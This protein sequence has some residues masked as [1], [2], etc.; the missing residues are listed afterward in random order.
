MAMMGS[1]IMRRTA[2]PCSESRSIPTPAIASR[3][4]FLKASTASDDSIARRRD[5][6][7]RIAGSIASSVAASV[8]QDV[9]PSGAALAYLPSLPYGR[10][11]A[12]CGT[13]RSSLAAFPAV[14]PASK[15][16]F[17]LDP[18]AASFVRFIWSM[19]CASLDE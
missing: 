15:R 18:L 8:A 12:I 13:F 10:R 11:G 17:T 7:L 6:Q 4:R 9:S 16:A 2:K 14:R 1:C 3:T 5:S 19:M